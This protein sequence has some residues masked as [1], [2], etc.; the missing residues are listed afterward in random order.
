M[1]VEALYGAEKS[2]YGGVQVA[3]PNIHGKIDVHAVVDQKRR[4]EFAPWF[5][6]GKPGSGTIKKQMHLNE[7]TRR[8]A[9][10]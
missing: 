7:R 6:E 1:H 10:K 8:A 2:T 5:F 9:I 4:H 3:H